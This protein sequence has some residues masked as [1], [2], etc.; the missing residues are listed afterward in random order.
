MMMVSQVWRTAFEQQLEGLENVLESE[1]LALEGARIGELIEFNRYKSR[2]FLAL[3]RAMEES[4]GETFDKAFIMRLSRL[5]EKLDANAAAL[6][7]HLAAIEEIAEVLIDAIEETEWDGT[8]PQ[9]QN[10]GAK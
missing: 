3:M 9:S 6:R 5:R 7:I 2:A 4:Q 10:G 8:Y 1:I